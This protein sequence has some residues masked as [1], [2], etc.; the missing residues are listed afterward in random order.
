MTA[1]E[2]WKQ[3]GLVGDWEIWQFG[4]EADA[5]E[6]ARL[7]AAGVK[8]ATS[9]AWSG[10]VDGSICCVPPIRCVMPADDVS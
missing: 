1:D 2:A 7:A 8:T 6:L 4:D 10:T 5:D 3:S 9:S